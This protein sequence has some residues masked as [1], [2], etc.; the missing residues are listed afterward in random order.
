MPRH[1]LLQRNPPTQ[2]NMLARARRIT[3][4]STHPDILDM[5]LNPPSSGKTAGAAMPR[6]KFVGALEE[7]NRLLAETGVRI[8]FLCVGGGA[9]CLAFK[10]REM[11]EDMDGMLRSP[12]TEQIEVFHEVASQTADNLG[13]AP[14]WINLQVGEIMK[15]QGVSTSDFEPHPGFK[16]SHLTVLFA[17]PALLL[18]M[19]CQALRLQRKDFSDVSSLIRLL[20]LRT[21]EALRDAV[22]PYMDWSWIGNDEQTTLRLAIAWAFPGATAY[23]PLRTRALELYRQRRS[24]PDAG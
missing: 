3:L 18:A 8:T 21:I 19:K 24:T 14:D 22:D 20:N 7:M 12:T 17:K 6:E 13:L 10:V 4:A 2:H 1:P 5:Y 23:E 9:M 11:T 16:W 15:A